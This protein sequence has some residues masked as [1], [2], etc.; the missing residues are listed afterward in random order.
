MAEKLNYYDLVKNTKGG[1]SLIMP[2]FDMSTPERIVI[3]PYDV[4]KVRIPRAYALGIFTNGTLE[5]MY[6]EGKFR[7][8]PVKQFEEEVAEVF[9]PV[10]DKVEVLPEEE[11]VRM[12]KQGNRIGIKKAL[13]GGTTDRD[14]VIILAREN[15]GDISMSMIEDMNAFLGVELQ[16]DNA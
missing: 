6:K 14:N 11:I 12:L 2:S 5:Q 16:I 3:V 10:E 8:E 4:K 13:E 7:I 15:I 9:F 1:L